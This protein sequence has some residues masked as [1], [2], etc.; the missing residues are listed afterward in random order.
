MDNLNSID[1]L[2]NTTITELNV[3]STRLRRAAKNAGYS[4][5][6]SLFNA[7]YKTLES[8][9]ND[10]LLDEIDDLR[11]QYHRDALKFAQKALSQHTI[12]TE[13]NSKIIK[14][15]L[16]AA[17]Q[18]HTA[19]EKPFKAVSPDF[20]SKAVIPEELLEL[21]HQIKDSLEE[22]C[23]THERP[24]VYQIFDEYTLKI[25]TLNNHFFNLF[26]KFNSNPTAILNTIQRYLPDAFL[27][28]V[29]HRANEI[30]DSGNLW[31]NIFKENKLSPSVQPE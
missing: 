14:E 23:E 7:P 5:I 19:Q 3:G 17:K 27:L 4:N 20:F 11:D 21:Q 2:N 25:D 31:D 13:A 16:K 1:V 30:F 28:H 29:S 18:T 8:I 24:F 22:L 6:I 26:T 9:F 10:S 15:T 12:D